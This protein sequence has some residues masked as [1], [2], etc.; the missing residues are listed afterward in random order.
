MYLLAPHF[1][2]C[3]CSFLLIS[4]SHEI[5]ALQD[6]L[7]YYE[8]QVVKKF[9]HI[10]E[11]RAL[12]LPPC[13]DRGAGGYNVKKYIKC[14]LALSSTDGM[15]ILDTHTHTHTHSILSLHKWSCF[16]LLEYCSIDVLICFLIKKDVFSANYLNFSHFTFNLS[17]LTNW[18]I[19]EQ[20]EQ[21]HLW[22]R[23]EF[24]FQVYWM[25]S[26]LTMVHLVLMF[27]MM[28]LLWHYGHLP[29][30]SF[31]L[32]WPL[33]EI[34]FFWYVNCF[35]HYITRLSLS[36]CKGNDWCCAGI[37]FWLITSQNPP[38]AVLSY[39]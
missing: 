35:K 39:S 38:A 15:Y 31:P 11:Y 20:Q 23:L 19:F 27:P 5:H 7:I 21:E 22:M 1:F 6:W 18:V 13:G 36:F 4:V 26:L 8:W 10:H 34:H 9:P 33:L 16:S 12:R 17:W 3:C 2:L 37:W 30:R 32:N 24:S 28:L 25:R 29:L 14:Q